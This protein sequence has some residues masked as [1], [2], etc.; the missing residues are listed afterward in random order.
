[1]REIINNIIVTTPKSEIK[2]AESEAKMCIENGGGYYFRKL[3]SK[4]K[5][6]VAGESKIY[7]VEDGYIRGR[8]TIIGIDDKSI[9]NCELTNKEWHGILVWMTAS[10]WEW[11]EPIEMK[12]FQGWR[13]FDNNGVKVVGTWKDKKPEIK[14][15]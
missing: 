11:I 12:G 3:S 10:S 8:A 15:H 4:P 14:N 2:N 7:Y 6:I 13:Y 1:M 5:N 9:Q